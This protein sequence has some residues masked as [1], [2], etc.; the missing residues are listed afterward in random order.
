MAVPAAEMPIAPV[1]K[2]CDDCVQRGSCLVSEIENGSPHQGP[3]NGQATSG[4]Q[5][6][7]LRRGDLLFEQGQP[8]T[9][10][11]VIGSGAVKVWTQD[12]AGDYQVVDFL[13]PGDVTGFEVGRTGCHSCSAQALNI[14]SVCARELAPLLA[15]AAHSSAAIRRLVSSLG[16][17]LEGSANWRLLVGQKSAEQRMAAFIMSIAHRQA[18]HGQVVERV[19]LPMSRSDIGNYLSLAVETVSRL[20]ARLQ[21]YGMIKVSRSHLD[22]LDPDQLRALADQSPAEVRLH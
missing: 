21:A 22:V 16:A 1:A 11:Y 4:R 5:R 20:L 9:S 6:H 14:T 10:V 15:V 2:P 7:L 13:G 3:R 8:A 18:A 19:E 12:A 17:Q